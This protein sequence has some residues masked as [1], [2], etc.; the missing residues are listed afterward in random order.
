MVEQMANLLSYVKWRGDLTFQERPLNE[1]DNLAFSMIAYLDLNG[2]VRDDA[3]EVSLYQTYERY[4][5]QKRE[6]DT[7]SQEDPVEQLFA[8]MADSRRYQNVMLSHYRDVL[9]F[10][11][12]QTQ[13]AALCIQW[14]K[15][16]CYLAFRGT[17]ETIIGWQEDF[18]ISFQIAPAQFRAVEYLNEVMEPGKRYW[19]GGH[20][21]GGNLAV[22]ASMMC[23]EKNQ[24]QIVCI[25]SND[26]PGMCWEVADREKYEK[27]ASK[28]VKLV[29]EFCVIGMLFEQEEHVKVVGSSGKGILQHNG[30][31]WEIQGEN[32]VCKEE[33]LSQCRALNSVLKQW[34]EQADMEHREQFIQDFFAALKNGNAK[35]ITDV[36]HGGV[37]GFEDILVSMVCSDKKTKVVLGGLVKS[38]LSGLHKLNLWELIK[39]KAVI[40]AGI[41]FGIGVLFL[42]TPDFAQSIL[43]IGFFIWLLFFSLF[44]LYQ[45]CK[46]EKR[47]EKTYLVKK[48]AYAVI[49]G[50][51]ILCIVK[52]GIIILSTNFIIGI[53]F[54]WRAY[55]QAGTAIRAKCHEQKW[56]LACADAILA[57]CLGIVAITSL[58]EVRAEVILTT[59]TYMAVMGMA[60]IGKEMYKRIG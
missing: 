5:E 41:I 51:E 12:E 32:F 50:V 27:I 35:Y 43:G 36:S 49:A 24:K 22:Y 48:A 40:Q 29:P 19:I 52:N 26:G 11:K 28:L 6:Q 54:L 56:M 8:A 13:F 18:S 53:F 3:G 60:G 20:S 57:A 34:I 10:G 38:F 4:V 21:K 37:G 45:I 25:Y 17:D 23:R 44:R 42:A 46:A 7:F 55:S 39:S 58:G 30:M 31:T 47:G 9:D 15:D 1:A 16:C 14:G 33:L 59:G 2:I